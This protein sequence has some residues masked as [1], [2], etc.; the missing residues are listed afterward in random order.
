VKNGTYRLERPFLFALKT[1]PQGNVK[2]FVD[3]V[4]SDTAARLLEEEGLVAAR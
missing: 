4:L 1:Q 3:F 2:A